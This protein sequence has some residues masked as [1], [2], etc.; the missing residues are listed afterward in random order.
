VPQVELPVMPQV[1]PAVELPK[2]E[3]VGITAVKTILGGSIVDEELEEIL[4]RG[5]TTAK[6][7]TAHVDVSK[8]NNKTKASRKLVKTTSQATKKHCGRKMKVGAHV[9]MA[10]KI[11]KARFK[12][13]EEPMQ[14]MLFGNDELCVVMPNIKK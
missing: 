5:D 8:T 6:E 9:K 13:N 10:T 4:N 12:T 11:L 7:A 14:W 2:V 3:P 1:K